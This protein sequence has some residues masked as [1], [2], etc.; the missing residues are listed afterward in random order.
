[1][2]IFI[3]PTVMEVKTSLDLIRQYR[4]KFGDRRVH[5]FKYIEYLFVICVA[6]IVLCY[7]RGTVVETNMAP[8]MSF[9]VILVIE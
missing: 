4:K 2:P 3:C 1:M 7:R 5:L 9:R 8:F 6:R